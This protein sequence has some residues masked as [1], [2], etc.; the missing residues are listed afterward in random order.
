MTTDSARKVLVTQGEYSDFHIEALLNVPSM[1]WLRARITEYR[2][3]CAA[4]SDW[5]DR[6]GHFLRDVEMIAELRSLPCAAVI[7]SEPRLQGWT[8]SPMEFGD[9]M[10]KTHPEVAEEHERLH[11]D[12]W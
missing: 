2:D 8:P 9:W 11:L 1:D 7:D 4:L 5:G 3:L 12:D 10:L 6:Q